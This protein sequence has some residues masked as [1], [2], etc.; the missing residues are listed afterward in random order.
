M[1]EQQQTTSI[2][3]IMPELY[4]VTTGNCRETFIKLGIIE[5]GFIPSF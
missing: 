1:S 2:A 4:A 3:T 5:E